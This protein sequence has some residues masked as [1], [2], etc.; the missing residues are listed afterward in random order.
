MAGLNTGY[1]KSCSLASWGHRLRLGG[2]VAAAAFLR[3]GARLG[4]AGSSA[5]RSGASSS[6]GGGLA[7]L[8]FPLAPRPLCCSACSCR[9]PKAHV[10]EYDPVGIHDIRQDLKLRVSRHSSS[11]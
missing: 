2:A 1:T 11:I 3:L 8:P 6:A 10:L 5:S 7:S 4:V 9:R